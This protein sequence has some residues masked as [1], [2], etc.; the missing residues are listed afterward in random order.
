MSG[1]LKKALYRALPWVI[2]I[3][4]LY[5]AF[6]GINW[7]TLLSHINE[8]NPSWLLAAFALTCF[9]YLLR[10]RRWQDLFPENTLSFANAARVLILGFFMNN[11]LPARAGE[12]VRA[13][14]GGRLSGQMRTLVLATIFSERL[15]DGLTISIMFVI[16]ALGLGDEGMSKDLLYVAYLFAAI[17]LGVLVLLAFRSKIFTLIEKISARFNHKA[18]EYTSSRLQVFINGLSPLSSPSRLLLI[19]AFSIAVWGVELGVYRATTLAFQAD[20]S[21]AQCVLLLVAVN[22]ASLIPAAP[23]GIGVIEAVASSVLV[24]L[25]L[26]RE[27][28][29][30]IVLAQHVIQYVVVGVPGAIIMLSWKKII[31][32]VRSEEGEP[33]AQSVAS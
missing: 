23:G 1:S 5:V 4:S 32:Q 2:T 27:H 22:F 3:I 8:A 11:V 12:F 15:V 17:A 30:T 26:T 14:L 25:G 19:G 24:S 29:L 16:F 18:A 7:G 6:H 28:A 31:A 10:S 33:E 13:H 21:W 9:S 20:L